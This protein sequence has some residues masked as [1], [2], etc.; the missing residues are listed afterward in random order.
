MLICCLSALL[1]KEPGVAE[2]FRA[3]GC[4]LVAG[5]GVM[6]AGSDMQSA[7]ASVPPVVGWLPS[8]PCFSA[9]SDNQE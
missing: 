2:N 8:L 5:V 4:L 9:V 1:P 3:V 7:G 6:A